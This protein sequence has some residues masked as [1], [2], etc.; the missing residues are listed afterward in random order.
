MLRPVPEFVCGAAWGG[1]AATG[2]AS[3]G[4]GGLTGIVVAG[5]DTDGSVVLPVGWAVCPKHMG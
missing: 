4:A 1:V 2:L 3:V 5:E